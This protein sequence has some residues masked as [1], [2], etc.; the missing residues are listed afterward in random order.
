MLTIVGL[1]NPGSAYKK[2]RHNAGFMLLDGIVEGR[3]IGGAVFQK[4]GLDIVRNF[5]GSRNKFKKTPGPFVAINGELSGKR[6]LLVKPTTFMNESGKAVASFITRGIVK[7]HSEFLVVVDDVD[8][9]VGSIRL[10][11]KGSTGG[12][13]GLK[14]IINNLGTNEFLRLRIGVGPRPDGSEMIDYVLSSL[15]PEE[16]ELFEESLSKASE[17]IEAWITDGYESAQNKISRLDTGK[18]K[19]F[20]GENL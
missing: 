11:E 5:F 17:V 1:G 14:S 3:F 15:R 20:Q 8:L 6:F 18:N 19:T 7:D 9:D 16:R 2:T 4:S 10:R 12:H 13:N